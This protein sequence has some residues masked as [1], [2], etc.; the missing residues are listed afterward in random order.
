M[1]DR[2]WKPVPGYFGIYEVSNDGLVRSVDRITSHGR[3]KHGRILRLATDRGGY[4]RFNASRDNVQQNL[5]VHVVLMA[6]FVGEKPEGMHCC[7]KNGDPSDNRLE[8]LRYDTPSENALDSVFQGTCFQ[9]SKE[10]CP[11][12]HEYDGANT[13]Y[14]KTPAG[15]QV[16]R[17][18]RTCDRARQAAK[19]AANRE[20]YN[21]AARRRRQAK[22]LAE[23][24]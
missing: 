19:R 5:L 18:C 24:A 10:R 20:S 6:A 14:V 12:G 23:A 9:A 16:G 8:N 11:S 17:Q 1:V 2:I 7:H 15:T 22:K 3:R 13:R 4:K 21:A